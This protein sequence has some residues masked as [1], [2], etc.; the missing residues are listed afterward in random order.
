MSVWP[1]DG[2]LNGRVRR[3]Q[4]AVLLFP[5]GFMGDRACN[6]NSCR[7]VPVLYSIALSAIL[8]STIMR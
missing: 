8:M 3:R 6:G 4:A 2:W 7:D 1:T 5:L